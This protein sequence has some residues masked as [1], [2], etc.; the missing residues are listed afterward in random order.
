VDRP[1]LF[2]QIMDDWA[3][4]RVALLIEV[5]GTIAGMAGA[6]LMAIYQQATPFQL[7]YTIFLVSNVCLITSAIMRNNAFIMALNVVFAAI[8]VLGLFRSLV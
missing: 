4:K 3:N 6:V 5:V 1:N 8:N 7:L 2:S